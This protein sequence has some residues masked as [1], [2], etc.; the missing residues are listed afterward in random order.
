MKKLTKTLYFLSLFIILSC[1][2]GVNIE[3][4]NDSKID[5]K[6]IV[7]KTGF[8]THTLDTL[9]MNEIKTIFI[10]FNNKEVR[11]DGIM[12]LYIYR[13]HTTTSSDY[14]FGYYSNGIPPEDM[15]IIIKDDT[16]IFKQVN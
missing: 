6:K 7:I 11:F 15:K 10:P 12:G 14:N 4:T 2:S 16:V 3:I 5:V 8:S 1:T 9:K 13:N